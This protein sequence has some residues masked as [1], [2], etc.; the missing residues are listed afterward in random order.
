MGTEPFCTRR[1]WGPH[2]RH[3][4][5]GTGHKCRRHTQTTVVADTLNSWVGATVSP[6]SDTTPHTR[7]AVDVYKSSCQL[8]LRWEGKAYL[9]KSCVSVHVSAT[10]CRTGKGL[11]TA[12]FWE[13]CGTEGTSAGH[14]PPHLPQRSPKCC[15]DP[16]GTFP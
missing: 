5:R 13:R 10:R 15:F 7:H 9:T 6:T 8:H 1:L 16:S 11:V 2:A 3:G 14:P 12:P 4:D